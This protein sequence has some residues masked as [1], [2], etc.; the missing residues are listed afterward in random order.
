MSGGFA[1]IDG[2]RG[3]NALFGSFG[4]TPNT[5]LNRGQNPVRNSFAAS[6][7][8]VPARASSCGNRP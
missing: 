3:E 7:F 2:T 8:V 5:A 4:S 6:I 1:F